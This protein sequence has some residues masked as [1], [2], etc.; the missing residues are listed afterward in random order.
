[1]LL[2]A[3]LAGHMVL[4]HTHVHIS[5]FVC[6]SIHKVCVLVR[7]CITRTTLIVIKHYCIY[8][9]K[10]LCCFF[11]KIFPK[12]NFLRLKMPKFSSVKYAGI[13][14]NVGLRVLTR[15]DRNI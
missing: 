3:F 7:I 12:E 4:T 8:V 2:N 5:E 1:M 11:W 6:V 15:I 14:Y 9:T 13:G 10:K